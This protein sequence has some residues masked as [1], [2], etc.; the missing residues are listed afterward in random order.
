VI[1][2]KLVNLQKNIDQD[3][4]IIPKIDIKIPKI[5]IMTIKHHLQEEM[6]MTGIE[7]VIIKGTEKE[8]RN[9][10]VREIDPTKKIKGTK[11]RKIKRTKSLIKEIRKRKTKR[12]KRK[13]MIKFLMAKISC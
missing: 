5:R 10:S 4:A 7:I 9:V 2:Q 6:T 11:R 8:K 3:P 1:S 12:T 13:R